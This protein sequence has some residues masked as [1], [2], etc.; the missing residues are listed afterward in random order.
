MINDIKKDAEGRMKKCI[1]SLDNAFKKIR[2]GRA[3]PS[4]LDSVRVNYYG[5]ET[6]IGQVAQVT[7]E[8]ARTLSISPWEKTMVTEIEKAILKS[9]LGLNPNTAGA[10]I[11]LIMPALTE[12]TRKDMI[13]VARGEAEHARVAVRT[14]R[15]DANQML[16]DLLKDKEVSEDDE[17]R[18]QEDVQKLTDKY[19]A[20]IDAH[21]KKK[22]QDLLAV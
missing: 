1:E 9:D 2:T 15:R 3:N 12:E 19:V 8:D 11:R 14:V 20:E 16:K 5:T 10:V 4:I 7:V 17:R 6:P 22:E 18:A 21:L 13:K